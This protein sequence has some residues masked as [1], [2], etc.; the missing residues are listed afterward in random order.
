MRESARVT[1]GTNSLPL[2]AALAFAVGFALLVV[3]RPLPSA[4]LLALAAAAAAAAWDAARRGAGLRRDA[5]AERLADREGE[6]AALRGPANDAVALEEERGLLERE[7]ALERDWNR[8]L[9]DRITELQEAGGA[10]GDTS[11]VRESVLRLA[12]D[13]LDADKGLLLSRTDGDGDGDLDLVCALGFEHDPEASAVTQHFARTVLAGDETVRASAPEELP[14]AGR[15]PADDEIRCLVA[16]PLY[17]RDRF[18]GVLVAANKEGGFTE[19]DDQVLLSLGSQAGTVLH[20]ARL[21]GET[22]R[23]HLA[24]VRLLTDAMEAKDRHLRVHSEAVARWVANVA[25]R[26]GL[27]PASREQLVF[28]S[29]LHDIGKLGVSEQ[30]LLKPGPLTPEEREACEQHPRIGAELVR[31]VPAL[32]PIVDAVLHHHERWDGDGYP[33]R[34]RGEQIPV[35]ARVI[36]VADAFSSMTADRPYRDGI[37]IA[38]ACE[39]LRRCAGTQFDPAVVRLFVDEVE[40]SPAEATATPLDHALAAP[41]VRPHRTGERL[42]GASVFSV[43]D[44]LTLLYGHRHLHETVEAEAKRAATQG[45]RLA[46]LVVRLRALAAVNAEQGFAAGDALLRASAEALQAVALRCG[47]TAAR[48]SGACLA[49]VVPGADEDVAEELAAAVRDALPAE[50]EAA[51]AVAVWRE[52]ER[53]DDMLARAKRDAAAAQAT[54]AARP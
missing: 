6:V 3:D 12:L 7:L 30:I 17:I 47:G 5:L 43:I 29:L 49:L 10:L 38:A 45:R 44:N 23:S 19:Y 46:T 31:Q 20:N 22:R 13:L 21:R 36:C 54:A 32:E 28:A 8:R 16:I 11:D 41:E 18:H 42:A 35:A 2:L 51:V 34:L 33:G 40:R 26:L 39:E 27:D 25:A 24:I 14:L 9:R 48:E 53:G 4:V 52:G 1:R 50:A 37:D 15:T